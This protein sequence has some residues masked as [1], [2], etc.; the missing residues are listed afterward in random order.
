M[1]KENSDWGATKIYMNLETAHNLFKNYIKFGLRIL[2]IVVPFIPCLKA[3]GSEMTLNREIVMI[4]NKADKKNLQNTVLHLENYGNRMEL[5]K[6]WEAAKWI[7]AQFK[8]AGLVTEILTYKWEGNTWPNVI[9]HID[10]HTESEEVVMAIAHLDSISRDPQKIALGADD[11]ASGVAVLLEVARL[12]NDIHLRKSIFFC[13]FSNE[14][15]GRKGSKAF[16]QN[17]GKKDMN[18]QSVINLDVLGYN[19]P[20]QLFYLD[21]IHAQRTIKHKVKA[22][23]RM[24]KNYLMGHFMGKNV[25]KIAG[26]HENRFLVDRT[27]NMISRYTDLKVKRIIDK[28]CG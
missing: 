22:F 12:I 6:Q 24:G 27:S 19:K 28:D 25:Y 11:N 20:D 16:V 2:M 4:I 3:N 8:Q 5:S 1:E 18:I 13:I 7:E 17:I 14:E 15:R 21:A 10:G 26:R 23:Y 9:A